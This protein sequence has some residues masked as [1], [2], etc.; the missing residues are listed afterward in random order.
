MLVFT[1]LTLLGISPNSARS[2]PW[3]PTGKYR[4][5]CRK[6]TNYTCYIRCRKTLQ[7]I[8][9]RF[10]TQQEALKFAT[11]KKLRENMLTWGIY[12]TR[13]P[14]TPLPLDPG[15]PPSTHI[16]PELSRFLPTMQLSRVVFPQPLAPK[17][18]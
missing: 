11:V 3:L 9:W 5:L 10:I 13:G 7:V 14:G 15:V 12:P 16:S 6:T 2:L 1:V 4:Y 18:P 17:R 8:N